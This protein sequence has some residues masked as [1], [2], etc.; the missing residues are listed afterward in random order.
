MVF[1]FA[2]KRR[3]TSAVLGPTPGNCI[4][5][6]LAFSVGSESMGFRSPW[7]FSRIV[8]ETCFI[9]L[10]LFLYSPPTLRHCSIS[11]CLAFARASGVILNF[12]ERFSKAFAVFL[13]A[14]FCEIIVTISV[15][16]G[17]SVEVT[18]FGKVK[19]F[20]SVSKMFFGRLFGIS[21]PQFLESDK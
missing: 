21:L 15:R 10:A 5:V 7:Y 13:S 8:F 4:S 3:T 20:R 6:F 9:V 17:S 2:V 19:V 14:V 1:F 11:F 16:K 18:H 12:F